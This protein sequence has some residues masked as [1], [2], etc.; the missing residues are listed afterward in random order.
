[1]KRF[2]AAATALSILATI[3]VVAQAETLPGGTALSV[4]ITAPAVGAIVPAGPIT[5]TGTASIA[6]GTVVK[7]TTVVYVVDVSGSTSSAAGVD[8]D[9]VGGITSDDTVLACEKAAV[10]AVNAAASLAT[11]PVLDSGIVKFSGDA[12]AI[13]LDSN[14]PDPEVLAPPGAAI[15]DALAGLTAGGG[16]GFV[17]AV[18][19]AIEILGASTA[20]NKTIV[21][22]SDGADTAGGVLPNLPANTFV[23]AFAVG[24]GASCSGAAPS[25]D[26]VAALGTTPSSCTNVTN[27]S[28]LAAD[29]LT[30]TSG[31][32][33]SSLAI[34]VDAGAPV[35]LGNADI[36][37]DLP[38]TGPA[39]VQFSTSL[40]LPS[41]PHHICVIA[42]G[43]DSGG[44]GTAQGC[45]DVQVVD[46][47]ANCVGTSVC[48][49]T[50]TDGN[51][52]T[53]TFRGTNINEQVGL[54]SFDTAPGACAGANC[55][56]AFDVLFTSTSGAGR[57]ELYVVTA[58][59]VSTPFLKAAIYINDVKVTR[60]C[61]FNIITR[62]EKLPCKIIG[63]MP[64]GGTFYYVKFA[65]DPAIKFR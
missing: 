20:T 18:T 59:A 36:T 19:A 34:S 27:L 54:R 4:T 52:A 12:V 28:T 42:S 30:Q 29:V 49:A 2:V 53:A 23:K 38:A 26:M 9:G 40:T 25:L 62:V 7:N 8:C 47:V 46:A 35:V 56:T 21:F 58:P 16:T 41:G 14:T 6:T 15:T 61:L 65:A 22:L 3:P 32:T 44:S 64:R 17:A 63:P 45:T 1:M 10:Q 57:A 31:S 37:P 13:D 48:T 33:L 43:S 50:A 24:S 60:S 11:S 51:V 5:V 55:V 39:S